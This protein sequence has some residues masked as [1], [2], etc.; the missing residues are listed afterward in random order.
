MCPTKWAESRLCWFWG[1]ARKRIP[2]ENCGCGKKKVKVPAVR[3]D[4]RFDLGW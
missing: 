2:G 4:K 3:K 1:P